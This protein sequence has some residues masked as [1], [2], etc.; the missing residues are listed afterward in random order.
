MTRSPYDVD[1]EHLMSRALELAN[2]NSL[3][4]PSE[5]IVRMLE[6]LVRERRLED[7]YAF[8]IRQLD[9]WRPVDPSVKDSYGE[10]P[11][12]Q[13]LQKAA[14]L[15]LFTGNIDEARR[16]TD[17]SRSLLEAT[18]GVEMTK[19][20]TLDNVREI[21]PYMF[22]L[23]NLPTQEDF[24]LR[25]AHAWRSGDRSLAH[26]ILKD[27]QA[28]EE[29]GA[30]GENGIYFSLDDQSELTGFANASQISH[31]GSELTRSIIEEL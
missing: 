1:G 22:E 23:E 27:Y 29:Q 11:H 6:F 19:I 26:Q 8:S 7:A 31:M 4:D 18:A 20:N 14:W 12:P 10:Q 13:L 15:A 2:Q 28:H 25:I 17:Q 5:L 21:L 30:F 16:L 24:R 3:Y 9:D